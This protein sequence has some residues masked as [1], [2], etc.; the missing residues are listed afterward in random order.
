MINFLFSYSAMCITKRCRF[1]LLKDEEIKL[2]VAI[3]KLPAQNRQLNMW[4]SNF[5]TLFQRN[6]WWVAHAKKTGNVPS[7]RLV[8]C[9]C[10]S[11]MRS[12][13]TQYKLKLFSSHKMFCWNTQ[14]S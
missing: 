9:T 1:Y 11:T 5:R 10:F 4:L 7:E 6:N 2:K 14:L 12:D 3:Q 8:L 13:G